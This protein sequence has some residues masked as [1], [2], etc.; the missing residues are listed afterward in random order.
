M[1]PAMIFITLKVT[2][3]CLGYFI[4]LSPVVST[5]LKINGGFVLKIISGIRN[6][7]FVAVLWV[8]LNHEL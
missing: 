5:F 2:S 7:M 1:F 8:I 3:G 6:R 4:Y